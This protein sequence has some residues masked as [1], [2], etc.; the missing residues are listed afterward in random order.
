MQV[1][2][3]VVVVAVVA[4]AVLVLRSRVDDHNMPP[5]PKGFPLLGNILALLKEDSVF[6]FTR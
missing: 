1:L 3:V 2:V 4:V 6:Y 5:G